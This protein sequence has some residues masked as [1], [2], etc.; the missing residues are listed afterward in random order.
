VSL[1]GSRFDPQSRRV[2]E[3]ND[4]TSGLEAWIVVDDAVDGLAAGGLHRAAFPDEETAIA[5]AKRRARAWSLAAR[6]AELDAGG[7]QVLVRETGEI[8]PE[9]AY[10]A[11][12]RALDGLDPELLCLSSDPMVAHAAETTD[13]ANPEGTVPGRA[14]AVGVLSGIQA[15]L[16]A[17]EG[18]PR[19]EGKDVVFHGYGSLAGYVAQGMSE[20]GAMVR[21]AATGEEREQAEEA[22]HATIDAEAWT[23]QDCDVLVPAGD[24]ATITADA[25]QRL[26]ARGVCPGVIEPLASPKAGEVLAE[27]GVQYAPDV[28]V[29]PGAIVEAVLTWREGH[30][31]RVQDE[32]DRRLSQVYDRTRR[33]LAQAADREVPPDRIVAERWG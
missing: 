29:N 18:D 24:G 28:L 2:L 9:R 15:V 23:E 25:A 12:G 30:A 16:W 6:A 8:E 22:G 11:L 21:V 14:Q 7:G 26:E 5:A 31:P 19:A 10:R 1:D 32:I 27:R 20:E 17:L 33:V 4:E 13:R 3:V